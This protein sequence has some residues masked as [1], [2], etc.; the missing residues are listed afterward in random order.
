MMMMMT[1]LI[2]LVSNQT[3]IMRLDRQLS[4]IRRVKTLVLNQT[5][6]IFT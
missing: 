6:S 3:T 5:T 2:N 4:V 1:Y